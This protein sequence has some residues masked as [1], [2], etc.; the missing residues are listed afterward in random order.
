MTA[1]EAFELIAKFAVV[2]MC[3]FWMAEHFT[4]WRR[5]R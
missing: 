3:C 1:Y 4:D 5:K 2:A